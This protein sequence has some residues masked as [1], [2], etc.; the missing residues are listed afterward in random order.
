ML[1]IPSMKF[2]A[3]LFYCLFELGNL[4]FEI[5]ELFCADIFHVCYF[6]HCSFLVLCEGFYQILFILLMRFFNTL[7]VIFLVFFDFLLGIFQNPFSLV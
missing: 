6:V 3:E 1:G 2:V 4:V 7:S 5:Q